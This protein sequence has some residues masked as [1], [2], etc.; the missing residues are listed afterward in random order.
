MTPRVVP[1]SCQARGGSG[2][3]AHTRVTRRAVV[4]GSSLHLRP[5]ASRGRLRLVLTPGDARRSAAEALWLQ[6]LLRAFARCGDAP[7]CFARTLFLFTPCFRPS[8]AGFCPHSTAASSFLL[9]VCTHP[10]S[11]VSSPSCLIPFASLGRH[12]PHLLR[13]PR[14]VP[15]HP[16]SG[17]AIAIAIAGPPLLLLD[18]RLYSWP[19][20]RQGPSAPPSTS[21]SRSVS[22]GTWRCLGAEEGVALEGLF[23][24]LTRAPPTTSRACACGHDRQSVTGVRRCRRAPRSLFICGSP[25]PSRA[26]L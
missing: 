3:A 18:L 17:T 7:P 19:A 8:P 21:S 6:R 23:M 22:R 11:A 2:L 13:I 26:C 1:C 24:L 12:L 20:L 10:L 14:V 16:P 4:L 9:A 25:R 15:L 5:H